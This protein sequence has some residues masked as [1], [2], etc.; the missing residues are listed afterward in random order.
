[1]PKP[2]EPCLPQIICCWTKTLDLRKFVEI[3]FS[4][5]KKVQNAETPYNV[6]LTETPS[7]DTESKLEN[8]KTERDI[9]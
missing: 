1:M 8:C 5:R 2:N 7:K 9:G 3:P 6:C 4:S